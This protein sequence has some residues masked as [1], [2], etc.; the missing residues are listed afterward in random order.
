M[1]V[2]L[3]VHTTASDGTDSPERVVKLA[4]QLGMEAVAITDHD[5]LEG[6]LPAQKAAKDRNIDIV[7]G[8][9]LST[10]HMN[11]EIHI[12]GY[13][14]DLEDKRFLEYLAVFRN[15]RVDRIIEM[16]NK[17]MGMGI[18]IS[19]ERV[20]TIA[21]GG[22][23][24]RP[25]LA[26]ALL[27]TGVVSTI[28]EAFEKY[29]GSGG[30]AY[31]PRFK[32]SPTDAVKLI[33]SAKGVPVLA[34]PGLDGSVSSIADLVAA[35]LQGIEVYHPSHDLAQVSIYSDL[36]RIHGLIV[37]GGSDYHGVQNYDRSP[38]GSVTV[39]YKAVEKLKERANLNRL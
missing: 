28:N 29:I 19:Q 37:T 26:E 34:H 27:E 18:N 39:T 38:L 33:L 15:A 5:V 3:H 20:F 22:A 21:G 23:V 16:V 25:H 13:Y 6:I 11:R 7:P 14:M 12:L 8:V 17:L 24:G 35:G 30:S 1:A 10:V 32:F 9:E 2:D 31:V 36:A 4:L